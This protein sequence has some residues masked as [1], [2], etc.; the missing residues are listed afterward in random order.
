MCQTWTMPCR[1]IR[2]AC[3]SASPISACLETV[4]RLWDAFE[5]VAPVP[6]TV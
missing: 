4:A 1:V 3:Q 2:L 5:I 6:A